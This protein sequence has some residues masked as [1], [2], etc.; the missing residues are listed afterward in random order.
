MQMISDIVPLQD[1]NHLLEKVHEELEDRE[2][3]IVQLKQKLKD[4]K[5]ERKIHEKKGA[6]MV[7][8]INKLLDNT[9]K[10]S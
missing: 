3:T 6:L 10:T 2:K 7:Y 8:V 5:E 4:M 9:C 1:V